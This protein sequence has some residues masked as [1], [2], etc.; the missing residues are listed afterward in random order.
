MKFNQLPLIIS[1]IALC[2]AIAGFLNRNENEFAFVD[3][4]Y[5]FENFEYK[6]NAQKDFENVVNSRKLILDS[7]ETDL[8]GIMQ[9]SPDEE[10]MIEEKKVNI[11]TRYNEFR[12]DNMAFSQELDKRIYKQL[13]IYMR[14]Y[15]KANEIDLVIGEMEDNL[16]L[17][18]DGKEDKSKEI[19]EYINMKYNNK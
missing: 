6:K 19:L 10:A 2:I 8:R 11:Q 4:K 14:E 17:V 15:A 18:G 5:L 7:L 16:T 1:V 13:R 12:E 9:S 3:I